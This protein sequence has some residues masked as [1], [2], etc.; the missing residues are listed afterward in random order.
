M[1]IKTFDSYCVESKF[2]R[3]R[4][5]DGRGQCKTRWLSH[6]SLLSP[7][8]LTS[9]HLL[10]RDSVEGW[11][12]AVL[13]LDAFL[14]WKQVLNRSDSCL[15]S[16]WQEWH[17]AAIAGTITAV[18][19][20]VWYTGL[21]SKEVNN[22]CMTVPCPDP[23]LLTLLATIGLILTLADFIGPKVT[24]SHE[25]S[26]R[27]WTLFQILD[28]IFKPESW[29]NEKEKKLEKVPLKFFYSEIPPLSFPGLSL[30]CLC[31]PSCLLAVQLPGYHE[32]LKS[33]FIS[34]WFQYISLKRGGSGG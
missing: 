20:T 5:S 7:Y 9:D 22:T 28:K 26:L 19:L 32:G 14:G 10:V 31:W 4:D 21:V 13:A 33:S 23:S 12:E 15:M 2:V 11:R 24:V 25:A 8:H 1:P 3:W 30:C 6:P 18:F 16:A 29:T 17:P 27:I 34:Q